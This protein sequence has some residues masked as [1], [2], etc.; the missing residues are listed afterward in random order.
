MKNLN[1]KMFGFINMEMIIVLVLT[2]L[3]VYVISSI[4]DS[5]TA[6]SDMKTKLAKVSSDLVI[7]KSVITSQKLQITNLTKD[8]VITQRN[9]DELMT[10]KEEVTKKVKA[11]DSKRK[12][13][14]KQV[15]DSDIQLKV[16]GTLSEES[17]TKLSEIRSTDLVEHYSVLFNET[18]Q[19]SI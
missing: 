13:K 4:K 9:Y 1:K 15:V 6:Y 17:L 14:E 10:K 16:S 7:A 11:V 18:N 5:V 3:V 8:L 2:A 19:P 12:E